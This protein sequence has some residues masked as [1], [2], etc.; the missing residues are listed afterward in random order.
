VSTT[1]TAAV[2]VALWLGCLI[3]TPPWT[4]AVG[5]AVLVGAAR[6]AGGGRPATVLALILV[7][8]VL[9]GGGLAGGRRVLVER[10]LLAG[11]A[12]R[13]M[14]V[15]LVGRVVTEPR[16]TSIGAWTLVRVT[17]VNHARIVGRVLLH[18]EPGERLD[19]G[20]SLVVRARI[21]P[22]P[23]GG[24][25]T[26]LRTLGVSAGARP[27]R[28]FRTDPAPA[29]LRL[30]TVVR[31]RTARVF[32]Q[33]LGRDRAAMLRGLVL[34]SRDGVDDDLLR[35]AGLS[36]LV[37]VSGRHVAVVLAGV[38]LVVGVAG[39]G[40]RGRHRTALVALWWF[41]LLTRWQPSVLRAA[42]MA[43]L[44][45]VAALAGRRRDA[46]HGLAVTVFILLLCDPLLAR[47]A[48]FALSVLATGGVLLAVHHGGSRPMLVLR[49]TV[50]AQVATAPVLLAMTGGIPSAAVPANLVA[51]PA[52]TVAQTI[53]L[54]AAV[55]A[56]L[57]APGAVVL[58]RAAGPPLGVVSWAAT[59]FG[60]LPQLGPVEVCGVVAFGVV[61]G[62]VH[63]NRRSNATR[64]SVLPLAGITA[65][66]VVVVGHA[67]VPPGAPQQLRLTAADVG[68]GDALL[69]EAPD[70]DDGARM[71]VDAGP[72]PAMIG[73]LLRRRRIRAIDVI[74]LTHGDHDH[75]GGLA[76]V[77]RSREVGV[78]I[79]P[80]GDPGLRDAS[81]S[82][83]AALEVARARGV[84]VV[85]VA[86]GNRFALGR[87]TVDVL[88]PATTIGRGVDRN[89]RSIVLRV[90]GAHG[91]ILLTGDAEAATQ[92][93]LLGRRSAIRADV[94]KVPHH[95]GATN[96]AG[97]L[98][99]VRPRVAVVSVGAG[100]SYGHPHPDT[101]A[102]IAPIPLWRTDRHGTVTVTL[103]PDGPV[104]E[105]ERDR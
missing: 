75:A 77:L 68:Q 98:D 83:R 54:C 40:H 89:T 70:A 72:E 105:A 57:A 96:A 63:R 66:V 8:L 58:A 34:G 35:A 97:F 47:Q 20:A 102:D 11:L 36:H 88:A 13:R 14:V 17:R 30:T 73:R 93:R 21:V 16:S 9:L 65:V 52:A 56:A 12:E 48:G 103:G 4:A 104:V 78:L 31:R 95:G 60:G 29:P 61:V 33:A 64:N 10:S 74:V 15:D 81:D 41:V 44:V 100:N 25:G 90:D 87:A 101:V 67:V 28:A 71:L 38:L 76:S 53:G 3:A 99:A 69:V 19:V 86:D 39:V 79:V 24:F 80:A 26:Y 85:P 92:L 27:V 37:V 51:A 46:V 84:P 50:A 42:V 62:L 59:A 6:A 22:L 49:A 94:L 45:L 1:V 2:A 55:P 82:A 91:R 5:V 32:D 23:D 43:T 18:T 7:A